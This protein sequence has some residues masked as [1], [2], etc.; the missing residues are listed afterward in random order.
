MK[1]LGPVWGGTAYHHHHYLWSCVKGINHSLSTQCDGSGRGS[2][3]I[4]TAATT[5]TTTTSIIGCDD[6][7]TEL[8]SNHELNSGDKILY[9]SFQK[10]CDMEIFATDFCLYIYF[11]CILCVFIC[12]SLIHVILYYFNQLF[13]HKG[14]TIFMNK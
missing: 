11:E 14:S 7:L 13:M 8:C 10:H 4:T 6:M 5:T 2:E 3:Q 12:T 9:V 1:E